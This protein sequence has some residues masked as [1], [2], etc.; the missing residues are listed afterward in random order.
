MFDAELTVVDMVP[1]IIPDYAAYPV[2]GS[3]HSLDSS[4]LI[5]ERF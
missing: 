4:L 1:R 3:A 5:E 2:F